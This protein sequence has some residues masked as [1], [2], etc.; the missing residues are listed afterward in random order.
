[1]T[2]DKELR[3]TW[4]ELNRIVWICPDCHTEHG[5]DL[6]DDKLVGKLD[7]RKHSIACGTCGTVCD[8]RFSD[9]LLSIRDAYS[10][11]KSFKGSFVVRVAVK[12]GLT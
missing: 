5:I 4:D 10:K 3:L 11:A 12:G 7:A 9:A 1:M 8:L 6:S 2:S